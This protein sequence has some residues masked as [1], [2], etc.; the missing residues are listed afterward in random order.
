MADEEKDTMYECEVELPF[1][2]EGEKVY[3]WVVRPCDTLASGKQ[4]GV[5]CMHCHGEVR[6]HKQHVA[7]GPADHVEHVSHQ[8]SEHCRGGVYFKEPHKMSD[9]PV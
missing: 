3:R 8:D 5:R 7:H 1:S 6:V 2:V 9:N 4:R